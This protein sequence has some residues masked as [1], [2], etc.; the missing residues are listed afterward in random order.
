MD[1]SVKEQLKEAIAREKMDAI[2]E[3]G[4]CGNDLMKGKYLF[5]F[6]HLGIYVGLCHICY[7]GI[8]YGMYKEFLEN[9]KKL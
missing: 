6:P 5:H 3:C 4:R 2:D 1:Q 7:N 9:T 8:V